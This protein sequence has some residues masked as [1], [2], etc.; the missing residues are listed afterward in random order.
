VTSRTSE[1]FRRDLNQLPPR[2]RRLA[3]EV[4]RMF[5][6]DPQHP[7]LK[8]KKL[9]PFDDIWSVRI[10]NNYR[11]IGRMKDDVIVWF[12]IGSHAD[13]DSLLERL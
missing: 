9:P 1:A 4:Y 12:F 7:S 10:N 3:R 2:V 13:Y 6:R 11:A 8:F 5:S